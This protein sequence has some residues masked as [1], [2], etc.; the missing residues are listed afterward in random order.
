MRLL[1]DMGVNLQIVEWLRRNGDD[2]VH[3]R[4]EGLQRLPDSDIF[5]KAFSEGRV[6][7]TFD[8]DFGEIAAWS[9]GRIVSVILFRLHNTR[10]PHV[11]QRLQSALTLRQEL[12]N[13]AVMV[14]EETRCRVRRLPIGRPNNP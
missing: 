6:I 4:D 8:L 12:E 1:A 10:T 13:G 11:I 2:A 9:G 7:L 3:L 5:D 14:V